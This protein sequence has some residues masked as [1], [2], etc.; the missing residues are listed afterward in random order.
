[1]GINRHRL[2]KRRSWHFNWKASLERISAI[3]RQWVKSTKSGKEYLAIPLP[4]RQQWIR[5]GIVVSAIL[6]LAL[7]AVQLYR[8]YGPQNYRLSSA[9]TILASPSDI[10]AKDLK[11]DTKTRTFSFSHGSANTSETRQNGATL[12]SAT[13]PADATKG[14]TVTDPN[15]K[16]DL[17]MKPIVKA[18]EGKQQQ[19]RIIYPIRD[20]NGWLVYTALG[21]GIREDIVLAEN[22]GDS[23]ALSYDLTL[24]NGTE[25][26]KETDG[27]IGIYGNEVFMSNVTAASEADQSLLEK[28]RTNAAKN[29]LLFTIPKPVV[30]ESGKQSSSVVASFDLSGTR[31]A[32]KATG[33]ASASYPLTI[34]P[35]IYIVTAQQFMNGNNETNIDFDVADKLIRKAPTT[36]ARFNSWN[37]TT[38]LP[39]SNWAGGTTIA[40][41]YIYSAGGISSNSQTYSTQGSGTFTVPSGI[42]SITVKLWGGGG[43]GGAGGSA[44]AGGAGGGAGETTGTIAVTPGETLDVYVGGGGAAGTRNTSG[45]G[46]GGGGYTSIY[47]GTTLL[48]LAAG[49][50][51]GGGGRSTST[52]IGGAGGAGGGTN[53]IAGSASLTNGGG[54]A[55]TSSGGLGG[56]STSGF[57]GQAGISLDGGAGANGATTAGTG[58]GAAG[59]LATGGNG[60]SVT[61]TTRAA[62]G[63]GGSGWFG[64]GGGAGAGTAAGGGGGGGGSSFGTGLTLNAGSGRTPGNS[65]DTDRAGAG[66]GGA[67][68]ARAGV[69]TAGSTGIALI[70]FGSGGMAASASLNWMQLSTTDGTLQSPNPGDG[71]CSGWCT[72]AAYN[73][74]TPLTNFSMLSYNGF[75]Y[76]IGGMNS[77]GTVQNSIYVAKLGANGEPQLWNPT[78]NPATDPTKSTWSYWYT[79]TTTLSSARSGVQ[80]VAY[81]NRLYVSGGRTATVAVNTMEIADILPT[82]QIGAWSSGTNLPYNVYNHGSYV[83]NDRIYILGGASTIGGAPIATVYYNK[84]NSNGTLNTWLPTTSMP[85]ARMSNGGNFTTV[86]GAYVYVSGGCSAVIGG[87]K[88]YCSTILTDSDVASINADGS[89]DTWNAIGTLSDQRTGQTL[90]AWR[91]SIYQIGGCTAQ[92]TTTGACTTP[93][94]AVKYGTVNQDGDAS[95]VGSSVASGTAPCSGASP[96]GCNMP[97]VAYIGNLLP[98]SFISNGYLYLVG[99]CVDNTC[100]GTASGNSAYTAISST[101]IMTA[102]STCPSPRT[103]QGG[104]WCVDTT[105]T[106]STGVAAASPVVFNGIVYLVGG[107]NGGGNIGNI[108]YATISQTDGSLS[109][110]TTQALSSVGT[111][112]VNNVSYLHAFARANPSGAGSNAP[113]NLYILGGCTASSGAGCTAYSANVYKCTIQTAG[114]ISGCTMTGQQQI[115]NTGDSATGLGIMSGTVYANYIYLIGGVTPNLVDLK[116]VHYAKIDNTNNI[117]ST[118]NDTSTGGWV[119]SPH[120]MAVG[121]RRSAAFGYNGYLYAVG[122]YEASTGVLADIEFIKINVSDGSLVSSTGAWTVSAVQI[123]QRWGLTVPISNSY[124]YV[125]G[126]CTV[127]ASPGGCTTRT[128]V[129]QTFQVYNNDSGAPA[130]YSASSNAYTTDPN[131]VGASSTIINGKMY[132][133]GGCTSGVVDCDAATTNVSYTTI[134]TSGNLGPW[135]N[136]T[137]ALPAARTWG[138]LVNTGGSLYYVGGQSS[139]S[140]DERAEVYYATP[141][142]GGD[143]TSWTA[144]TN[145]LPSARTKLGA[146]VWNNRIY[147]VG[148]LDSSSTTSNTVY[149]SPQLTSGGNIGTAWSTASTAFNVARSGAAVTSYANNLYLLGGYSGANYLSDVQYTQIDASTGLVSGAW[150][151]SESLPNAVS[152]ADSFAANG[153]IYLMGGRSSDTACSRDTLVAPISANTTID[154]GNKPTGVGAWYTTNQRF[155]GPRYGNTAAYYDGKAYI[156]GGADCS[157]GGTAAGATTTLSTPGVTT[158]TVPA[159]VTYIKVKTWGAGGGGGGGAVTGANGGSGGGGAYAT[160]IIPVTPGEVLSVS[161]GYAGQGGG[162]NTSGFGGGGGGESG[163]RRTDGG[164]TPLII[165][166]SGGGGGGARNASGSSGG[167]G[168]AAGTTTGSPGASG[169]GTTPFAGG[170]GG[171]T[172]S[173]SGAAGTATGEGNSCAAQLGGYLDG[174]QGADGRSTGACTWGTAGNHGGGFITGAGDGGSA[175]AT[176]RSGGAGGGSGYYG[177]GG[178]A[179]SGATAGAGG[180]GGGS[181]Y[182]IPSALSISTQAATTTTPGNSA[183]TDR[184]GAGNGGT[185]GVGAAFGLAGSNGIVLITPVMVYATPTVQQTALLSQPQVAKY[186][187]MFDT[188][189]DVFPNYWL[190]N[191]VDNSIGARWQLKYRSMANQQAS[192]LCATM[193]TWGQ[194]TNFGDVVLG[195]PGV[196]TVKDGSGTNISCGRYFYFNVSVDSSQAFGYPDDVSRGPTIT[197]LTLQFTADPS[198]RLMHGRTFTGGLQ[199]PDDTPLYTN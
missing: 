168:G 129:I 180:G 162:R 77:A 74:P 89:I 66:Q 154:S 78:W 41:G 23:Y 161:V 29:L 140:T 76:V 195:T 84:I 166:G 122:G 16:V 157:T 34:D 106:I 52:H 20:R 87:G 115:N 184:G 149:V 98:V 48:A 113:G 93:T 164:S 199:M 171:G 90:L 26:R 120:Q 108:N 144:A 155:V 14:I 99:G 59:G 197:D 67:A 101:G 57:P 151:Y 71:V 5:I 134:D 68:G 28:A 142:A 100:S 97:G 138:K 9:E 198:K 103:I 22:Q 190:L 124:A 13:L 119:E 49:G 47:R 194:E 31:L 152:Q 86:W 114:A 121:R 80:A 6:L 33:L 174:G 123:N 11:Y 82:G 186:S 179:S 88:D 21:T 192:S 43:G 137:A 92:N 116:T 72:D 81:N 39:L 156:T 30:I 187:I 132:V 4:T 62:G 188:D 45:G 146:T 158:Y 167:A 58:S 147:A 64:G 110:W 189:T 75:L 118:V 169:A 175:I 44:A 128:D 183:D 27:S 136:T 38:Q 109:S 85:G 7:V 2:F 63:G 40:G 32:I 70:S 42:T 173:A 8:F 95:T 46:G 131:R 185:G 17:V 55:G 193:T 15:Y 12:V 127:G 50:G 91:N 139:T 112:G 145:G 177:G 61:S 117:V 178:G 163:I 141:T 60:G 196:Y 102:P 54:G 125:I 105:N 126:G 51:G 83:Y 69:G 111:P 96:Y 73:L 143:V 94:N 172:Q 165:A 170:G 37:S 135:S 160:G 79:S 181:T 150:K 153:Y 25:A 130:G 3:P 18:A 182:V 19:N 24:P 159:G 36:G 65:T 176:T 104:A 191:G 10:L 148:G 1:M 133:A 53:G 56:T 35:S 107:L